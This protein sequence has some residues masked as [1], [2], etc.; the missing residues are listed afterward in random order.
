MIARRLRAAWRDWFENRLPRSD[1]WSLSQRNI[2][3]VPTKAG[4]AFGM[5]SIVMLLA[6]INYQLNLGFA[7]TFLL[8]G[9]ALVSMHQTHA[10][11]RGLTLHVRS[12][13]PVFAGEPAQLEVAIAN[14]GGLRHGVGFSVRHGRPRRVAW[15]DVPAQGNAVARLS[16]VPQRRGLHAVPMLLAETRFPLG[17]FRAW[18][19]W[20][21]MAE[22]LVYPRPESPV[23]PLPSDDSQGSDLPQSRVGESGEFEGVRGYRRG[24]AM[25]RVVWKKVAKSGELVS[26]DTSSTISRE[27]WL[28][29]Q[30][31]GHADV[32]AR[33][34]RLAAWVLNAE[35]QGLAFG[36]RL[37][38]LQ[39]EAAD[40]ETQRRAAL[41]ALALWRAQGS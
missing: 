38:G 27:L 29:Y 28:D 26:R 20:R 31:A 14:A 17:L 36:L 16:F 15:V 21:P 13:A 23:Q 25:R 34:E 9:A 5:T 8:T 10:T 39:L 35:R 11:L 19:V 22:A 40:G 32:E 37:P 12:P 24:D 6:S 18:T 7:L 30:R 33:L 41:R 4:V 2:Y 3:I 1:S